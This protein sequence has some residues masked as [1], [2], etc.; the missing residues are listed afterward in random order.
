MKKDTHMDCVD[1][2]SKGK[3][4]KGAARGKP[5]G[6]KQVISKEIAEDF[7]KTYKSLG[8]RLFL[9]KF[10]K[11]SYGNQRKFFELLFKL[12]PDFAIREIF[13]FDQRAQGP[14]IEFVETGAIQDSPRV[15]Q[16]EKLLTE[17]KIALPPKTTSMMLPESTEII[18]DTDRADKEPGSEAN[19]VQEEEETPQEALER[20]F[21]KG[22]EEA[23]RMRWR[24]KEQ[25]R[26][27]DRGD[28]TVTSRG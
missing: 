10:A 13:S 27:E 5:K 25:K 16:L 22:D 7:F 28:W 14:F 19:S 9:K 11:A 8:G 18:H 26:L 12:V 15:L 20:Q 3:F 4:L 1:R 21:K 6:A 2:D 23:A 24:V 17:H